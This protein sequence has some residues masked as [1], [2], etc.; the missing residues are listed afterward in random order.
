MFLSR[1]MRKLPLKVPCKGSFE[2]L[3]EKD[4][5]KCFLDM[6]ILKVSLKGFFKGSF[7]GFLN[8]IEG[9]LQWRH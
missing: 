2:R 4:S 6:L 5:L 1:I 8:H 3:L 7:K 9:F